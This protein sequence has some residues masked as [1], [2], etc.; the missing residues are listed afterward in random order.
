MDESGTHG[1]SPVVNVGMYFGKPKTWR[2]WTKDWNQAKK[3]IKVYHAVDCHNRTNEFEGWERPARDAYVAK[4]LPALARHQIM[5]ITVGVHMHSFNAAMDGRPDLKAMFG[6]PYSACFQWAVQTLLGMLA[7]HGHPQRVAFFHENNNYQDEARSAFAYVEALRILGDNP[8]SL[9]FGTKGDF[10]PLQSADILAYEANHLLRDPSKPERIPWKIMNP[11]ADTDPE[12]RRI[13]V[14][15][16]G[17]N[18][19]D[20]LISLLSDYRAKLLAAGWDGKVAW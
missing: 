7:E 3:P 9:T 10:V 6:N 8:I 4:V 12:Q 16:Y 2:E 19:M 5:G 18:N 17:E 14:L 15:H 1:D 13:R 11:G 20:R